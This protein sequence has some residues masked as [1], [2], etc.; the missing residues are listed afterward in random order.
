M[1]D[2]VA[3]KTTTREQWQT[4]AVVPVARVIEDWLGQAT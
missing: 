4:A 1:F 3:Y 2:A